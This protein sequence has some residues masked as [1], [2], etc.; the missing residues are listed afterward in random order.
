MP[1]LTALITIFALLIVG[2]FSLCLFLVLL[3][4]IGIIGALLYQG[5][6]KMKNKIF[7]EDK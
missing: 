5:F 6:K 1:L 3:E 7:K 2:L 4:I